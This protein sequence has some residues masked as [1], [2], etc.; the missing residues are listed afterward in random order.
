MLEITSEAALKALNLRYVIYHLGD[1]FTCN[2]PHRC[3]GRRAAR[4]RK[5]PNKRRIAAV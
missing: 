2:N 4:F 5:H 3:S 1:L